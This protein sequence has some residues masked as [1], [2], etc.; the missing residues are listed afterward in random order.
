MNTGPHSASSGS[1]F[2]RQA[3]LVLGVIA[4]LFVVFLL[5][6]LDRWFFLR[7]V[8]QTF[9]EKLEQRLYSIGTLSSEI[10][11]NM[12]LNN[13]A[14][15][16]NNPLKK[17]LVESQLREI[18]TKNFLE[19][20][21]I[22][23]R[24]L[25]VVA[26]GQLSTQLPIQRTYIR[27]D[28]LFLRE[29]FQ[30]HVTASRLHEI[31]GQYFKNGYAPLHNSL[32]KIVGLL[33]VEASDRY[34]ATLKSYKKTFW[35]TLLA[36][37]LLFG[38]FSAF[39][40]GSFKRLLKLEAS[41]RESE[42]LAFMGKMAAVLAHEIR[43][44]L[45]IIRG[46]ADVLKSK[47][48]GGNEDELFDYIPSEVNRLNALINNFLTFAR[49]QK[50]E[51]KRFDL[52][53]LLGGIVR[54]MR[55][56]E[57]AAGLTF[58][59]EFESENCDMEADENLLKQVF[60]NILQNAVQASPKNGK[61]VISQ[62]LAER[63]RRGGVSL[64]F[65]DFGV[66]IEGEVSRIFEPFFTTKS[67]GTGLGMAISKKILE[68]HGGEIWVESTPGKGTAIFIWLPLLQ[69]RGTQA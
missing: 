33:V 13:L 40:W 21:Y 4:S 48:K 30:G 67:T 58:Q 37:I 28:S 46:T 35:A 10:I 27:E 16:E 51:V 63:K 64:I 41:L 26:E 7:S 53:A 38:I 15:I 45:G 2:S 54:Q 62:K 24:N 61:I 29:A 43:N 52:I 69:K 1:I 42:R 5:F 31:S 6:N 50:L 44:P 17:L 57:Q 8:F 14:E 66:G 3:I 55:L 36:S 56:D 68:A 60:L 22:V 18:K 59:E 9:D 19:A 39:I 34:F 32:G 25:R 49:E 65:Q 12:G 20:V 23:D 47:Y 11:E